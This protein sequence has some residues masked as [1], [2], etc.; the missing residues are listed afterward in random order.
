MPSALK[1][2][3]RLLKNILDNKVTFMAG[4]PAIWESFG[5]YCVKNKITLPTVKYLVMFGAPVRNK[6]HKKFNNVL[7]NGT[8]Y[9]PYGATES[10]PVSNISGKIVETLV[11]EIQTPGKYSIGFSPKSLNLPSGIYFYRIST[12]EYSQSKKMIYLK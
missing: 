1:C 9:T 7:L 10:L 11:N 6:L 12:N 4:S 3:K 8:T 2:S 5:S